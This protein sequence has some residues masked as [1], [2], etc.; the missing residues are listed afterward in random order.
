[1][2][3]VSILR[4]IPGSGKSHLAGR[5]KATTIVSADDFFTDF[6]GAYNFNPARLGE[7]HSAC[8][9]DYLLALE[10]AKIYNRPCHI[11]VDNTN[12][13]AVEVAPYAALAL[14]FG[15]ELKVIT[16]RTPYG[17]AACR[18]VHSVPERTIIAMFSRLADEDKNFPP[19]WPTEEVLAYLDK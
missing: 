5:I 9:R 3:K 2:I 13:R 15:A 11:V 7:A 1:M 14:A 17:I 18:N 6:Q 10:R 12:I 19:H 16:L 4:G 8:L